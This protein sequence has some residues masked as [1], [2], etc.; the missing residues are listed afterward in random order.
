MDLLDI[1]AASWLWGRLRVRIARGCAVGT[2]C[3][4]RSRRRLARRLALALVL[5]PR[6]DLMIAAA[7]HDRPA[8]GTAL[9]V[10]GVRLSRAAARQRAAKQPAACKARVFCF[11]SATA[12]FVCTFV[13]L[14]VV[15]HTPPTQHATSLDAAPSFTNALNRGSQCRKLVSKCAKAVM[16]EEIQCRRHYHEQ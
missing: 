13:Q 7:V 5:R 8:G 4:W 15:K 1:A 6:L 3:H 9:E 2:A 16:L 11:L 12:K 10:V 14:V